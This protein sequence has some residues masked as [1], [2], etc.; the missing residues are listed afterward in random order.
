[1]LTCTCLVLATIF[2]GCPQGPGDT[3]GWVYDLSGKQWGHRVIYQ[4]DGSL[5]VLATNDTGPADEG[6]VYV[7]LSAQGAVESSAVI[8]SLVSPPAKG[9]TGPS[10]VAKAVSDGDIVVCGTTSLATTAGN[11]AEERRL[12]V[13]RIGQDGSSR[14]D[15]T[16]G[17]EILK[18]RVVLETS[19][20]EI[21]VTGNKSDSFDSNLNVFFLKLAAD[22]QSLGFHLVEL[23]PDATNLTVFRDGGSTV[24][25]EIYFVGDGSPVNL[26]KI[27]RDLQ[28]DEWYR[29]SSNAGGSPTGLELSS[30]AFTIIARSATGP[31]RPA[32]LSVDL[33]GDVVSSR[34][35]IFTPSNPDET[36]RAN[37]FIVDSS[38]DIV[39]VGE[40]TTVRYIGDFFP[41]ITIRPF[42]AKFTADGERIWEKTINARGTIVNGVTETSDGGYA[43]TGAAPGSD[44]DVLLNVILF[45]HDGNIIN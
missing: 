21:I 40:G 26:V 19:T 24:E 39:M 33:Q 13:T 25:D 29:L 5:V 17:D 10:L 35:D 20:G 36:G 7:R 18:P 14:W 30:D 41:Q 12:R 37:D 8:P 22:G 11:K 9:G 31:E 34:D 6:V 3:V 28:I 42:I 38:G 1:M 15:N 2:T 27:N 23:A 4:G 44:G 32:L 16:Y 45:D 43:T